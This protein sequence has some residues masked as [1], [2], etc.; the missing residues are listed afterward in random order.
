MG[1][2]FLFGEVFG[3]LPLLFGEVFGGLPLLLGEVFGGLPLLLGEVFL[4]LFGEEYAGGSPDF[5][6]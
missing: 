5:G 2:V 3:G 1:E 4:L 6:V